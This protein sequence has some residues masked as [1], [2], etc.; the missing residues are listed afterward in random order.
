M[1]MVSRIWFCGSAS[2]TRLISVRCRTAPRRNSAGIVSTTERKGSIPARRKSQKVTYIP[3]ITS[4]PCAKLITRITPKISVSPM[5]VS[6]YT[7]PIRIP[8]RTDCSSSIQDSSRQTGVRRTW[9]SRPRPFSQPFDRRIRLTYDLRYQLRRR[10][11]A[12]ERRG[13]ARPEREQLRVSGLRGGS[14]DL[15]GQR[16]LDRVRRERR[17]RHLAREAVGKPARGASGEGARDHRGIVARLPQRRAIGRAGA[18][19]RTEEE[20]GP[21]RHAARAERQRRGET[22]SVHDASRGDDGDAHGVGDLR[23]QCQRAD[24]WRVR[25]AIEGP[26]VAAG[27]R[28]LGADRADARLL[29]RKSTRLNSSHMSISY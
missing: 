5:P 29:D 16:V 22:A 17:R 6:A 19:F 7:P 1:P 2:S 20:R 26:A 18:G 4:S 8:L 25:I 13:L 27:L 21:E 10:D 15:A 11:L 12:Q 23:D 9:S 14:P 3:T 28:S 24:Q